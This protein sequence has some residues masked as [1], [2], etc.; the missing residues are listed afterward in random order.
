MTLLATAGLAGLLFSGAATAQSDW[1]HLRCDLET[2]YRAGREGE[3][4]RI[5]QL[6][7]DF[8]FR[9]NTEDVQ[10]FVPG[11]GQWVSLC[12]ADEDWDEAGCT[13]DGTSIAS[14]QHS[15]REDRL[16][17]AF[18]INRMTGAIT[19]RFSRE[20]PGFWRHQDGEGACSAVSA[21]AAVSVPDQGD[22]P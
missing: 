15:A 14:L 13:I 17:N 16:E 1:T 7:Q 9:F 20:R 4:P 3:T 21:E 18:V 10:R 11:S 5:V 2:E 19:Y 12:V 22:Q 6:E 8:A